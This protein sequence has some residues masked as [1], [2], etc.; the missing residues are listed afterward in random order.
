[1]GEASIGITA[2]RG[3]DGAGETDRLDDEKDD[4]LLCAMTLGGF[5]GR[6]NDVGVP[7]AE[8]T[9]EPVAPAP[10]TESTPA[11]AERYPASDG[12]GLLVDIRRGGRSALVWL[13]SLGGL[14]SRPWRT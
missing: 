5:I 14:S 9:G 11:K 7:G 3:M 13:A 1:M 4:L 6:A 12:A 2:G 8:G 10:D